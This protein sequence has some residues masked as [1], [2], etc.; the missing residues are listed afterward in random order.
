LPHTFEE[1]RSLLS[2]DGEQ[3]NHHYREPE[4]SP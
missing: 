1:A 2:V 3:R 4:I